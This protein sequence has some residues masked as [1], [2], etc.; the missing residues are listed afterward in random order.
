MLKVVNPAE[1]AVS[2]DTEGLE[3]RLDQTES[4]AVQAPD[5][6]STILDGTLVAESKFVQAGGSTWREQ[7]G[8]MDPWREQDRE[9]WREQSMEID[10]PLKILEGAVNAIRE[11]RSPRES[12]N[13]NAWSVLASQ[14]PYDENDI[15]YHL[16]KSY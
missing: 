4:P 6:V 3:A 5:L 7:T 13:S 11:T 15:L 12:Q 10:S 1:I 8:L 16:M 2:K 9:T 14:S